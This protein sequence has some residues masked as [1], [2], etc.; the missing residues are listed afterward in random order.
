MFSKQAADKLKEVADNL[1]RVA[2]G[3]G[4]AE[5][6]DKLG[7]PNPVPQITSLTPP[8]LT[9]NSTDRTITVKGSGFVDTSSVQVNGSDR[10]PTS[11][12]ADQI[13]FELAPNDVSQPATLKI[14][15]V[16]P[17]PGG[18]TS[19]ALDLAITS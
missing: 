3:E 18:G 14:T 5:R 15:V 8:T 1:F 9:A 2:A 7:R 4:D 12:A 6:K 13:V 16:N 19:K 17:A 10:P 11:V